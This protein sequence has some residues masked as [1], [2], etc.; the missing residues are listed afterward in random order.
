VRRARPCGSL[1]CWGVVHDLPPYRL[2]IGGYT[3]DGDAEL[4]SRCKS[5]TVLATVTREL[6]PHIAT[7]PSAWEGGIRAFDLGVRRPP[8]SS[9]SVDPREREGLCRLIMSA[10]IAR[11]AAATRRRGWCRVLLSASDRL[12]ARG[13]T[14][15]FHQQGAIHDRVHL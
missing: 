6:A 14:R 10:R 2:V 4:G 3:R 1:R 13:A 9:C 12:L 5:D 8:A 7:G 11:A 15:P